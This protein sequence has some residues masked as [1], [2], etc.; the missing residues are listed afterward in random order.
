MYVTVRYGVPASAYTVWVLSVFG[1]DLPGTGPWTSEAPLL[2]FMVN[3]PS[4][5]AVHEIV[6]PSTARAL[7][8]P[9]VGGAVGVGVGFGFG[10]TGVCFGGGSSPP[11]PDS[12]PFPT[13]GF[14]SDP[15]AREPR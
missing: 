7:F 6:E 9:R 8:A 14:I 3:V 10:G 12:P 5:D 4:G 2:P 15:Y 1:T 11:D 13:I